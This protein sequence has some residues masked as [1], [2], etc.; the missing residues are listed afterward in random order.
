MIAPARTA[1]FH[2][3][4]A[5]NTGRLDL[6]SALARGRDRLRDDRDRGLALEIVTGTV[7]WQRSL[8]YLVQ[9]YSRRALGKVDDEVVVILRMSLYQLLHL[10]RV[11]AAAVVDDAVDLARAARKPSASGFVNAVLRSTLRERHHLPF[12]TRPDDSQDLEAVIQYLGLT[13]SHPDWL[14][15]RWL[16]RYGLEAAERWVRFNNVAPLLTI[17]ANRLRMTREALQSALASQ[18][19]ESEP[20]KYAPNGLTITS[21]N[22]IRHSTDGSFF[23]QDEASQLVPLILAARPGEAVLD[24]CAS[25][26]GKTTAIA[27]DMEDIGRLIAT[28]VRGRRIGLLHETV[29]ASGARSVRIVQVAASGPLPF[30]P[31]FDRVL[32]DAPCSG[33][34]TVRRDPDIRWRRTEADLSRLAGDQVALLTRAAEVVRPG[35]RLVYATCSSEPEEND[36]VVR[37]FLANHPTFELVDLRARVA[38]QPAAALRQRRDAENTAVR[39]RTGS[40]LRGGVDTTLRPL[41]GTMTSIPCDSVLVSG[42]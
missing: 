15:G 9:H 21:G 14:V 11:P 23:V 27:A 30:E 40:V 5:I 17:R 20:T 37:A 34:G 1:A 10:D 42:A 28:D 2:A 36:D 38:A 29:R 6:P 7:R 41:R 13:Q 32:V 31:V 8:D 25:P 4:L 35:G 24:L 3:L 16:E 22:P 12:P 26:G 39:T 19:V 33:L 18:G